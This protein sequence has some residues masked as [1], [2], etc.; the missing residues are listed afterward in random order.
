MFIQLAYGVYQTNSKYSQNIKDL[1]IVW[2]HKLWENHIE[3]DSFTDDKIVLKSTRK[4]FYSFKFWLVYYN[5][6][7]R[8]YSWV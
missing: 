1:N 4:L 7:V 3:L 5:A 8:V 2:M 6:C